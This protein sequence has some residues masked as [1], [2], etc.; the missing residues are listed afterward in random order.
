MTWHVGDVEDT[1][2]DTNTSRLSDGTR[3]VLFD[4]DLYEATAVA[5]EW[6]QYLLRPGDLLYFDEAMDSN[7]RQVLN[8]LVL[9]SREFEYV[10]CTSTGLAIKVA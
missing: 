1:L 2:A 3:I 6:V 9:P 7:E 8:E 10:D 5:W 4:L